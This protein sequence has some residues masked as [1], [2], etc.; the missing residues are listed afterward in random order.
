MPCDGITVLNALTEQQEDVLTELRKIAVG[1]EQQANGI[2][3]MTIAMPTPNGILP[4][5]VA[6][7]RN[8][9]ITMITQQGTF[10]VGVQALKSWIALLGAR[11]ISLSGVKFETHRH[12]QQAPQLAYTT[13]V[14]QGR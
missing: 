4:V 10:E 8:G 3:K 6:V 12:D 7:E 9:K 11:G 14:Q 2:V 1:R 13:A 5:K